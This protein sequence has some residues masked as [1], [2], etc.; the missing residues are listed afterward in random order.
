MRIQ[1]EGEERKEYSGRRIS[2]RKDGVDALRAS[3]ATVMTW[4][5]L[6][7][8]PAKNSH[9]VEAGAGASEGRTQEGL[10]EER[11][12]KKAYDEE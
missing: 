4:H 7:A 2:W 11:P 3:A 8:I 6:E 10:W 5:H 1:A 9:S 12:R